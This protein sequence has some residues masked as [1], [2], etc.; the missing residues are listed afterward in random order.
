MDTP[1]RFVEDAAARYLDAF[2]MQFETGLALV[3]ALVAGAE[4]VREAQLT[5]ARDTR[6]QHKQIAERVSKT[7][8]MQDMMVLQSSLLNEYCFGVVR[9]WSQLAEIGRKTQEDVANIVQKQGKQ[10]L[11]QAAAENSAIS[12]PAPAEPLVS[13]MQS[14]FNAARKANE[15]FANAL[16]GASGPA[17]IAKKP[18]KAGSARH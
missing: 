10:V 3:N 8:S 1:Q 13:A 17:A 5:A 11:A 18:G 14:A 12:L 15:S 2:R 9:Y 7:T 4:R 6:V 16:I